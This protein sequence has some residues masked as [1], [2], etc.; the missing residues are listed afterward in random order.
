MK[1]QV[2]VKVKP[3]LKVIEEVPSLLKPGEMGVVLELTVK[4]KD[5]KIVNHKVIKSKCFVK[6]FIQLLWVK[7]NDLPGTTPLSVRDITNTL[8]DVPNLDYIFQCD[9][10]AGDVTYGIIVGT[11]TTAPTINDYKIE[12]I[13]PHGGVA[14]QLN[15]A[16]TAIAAAASDATTSQVTIS[17][18]FANASGGDITVNEI[19]LYNKISIPFDDWRGMT[20]RD[21]ISGGIV[22][23]NGQTLTVNY[24]EQVVV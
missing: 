18:N 11:G 20:I 16:L 14:N 4:D 19:A 2:K 6:Q 21:V 1:T 23:A 5:G 7:L 24:R 17:R 10:P 13:V 15:Y 8:R 12:T 3:K 22:V 9:G